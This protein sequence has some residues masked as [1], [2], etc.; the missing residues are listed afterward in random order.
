MMPTTP[1]GHP[2]PADLQTVR[3]HPAV[4]HLAD[5]VGEVGDRAQPVG[6]PREPGVGEPQ[7]VEGGASAPPARPGAV[8]VVGRVDLGRPLAEQVGRRPQGFVPGGRR[9]PGDRAGGPL[10]HAAE[11]GQ[12]AGGSEVTPP[13]YRCAPEATPGRRAE[14]GPPRTAVAGA[15]GRTTRSS[16]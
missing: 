10:G 6:H 3:A 9:R 14:A 1:S 5:R 2:R 15:Q 13:A 16:R 11:L 8:G 12:A 4:E 7:P